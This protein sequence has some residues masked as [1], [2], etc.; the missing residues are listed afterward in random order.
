MYSSYIK[1]TRMMEEMEKA[2]SFSLTFWSRSDGAFITW[3]G[4]RMTSRHSSG[5]TVNIQAPHLLHPRKV[6][7]CLIVA[8]NNKQV[9]H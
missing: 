7:T 9:Y 3:K 6:R 2:K 1:F 4:C 8:Y 5:G